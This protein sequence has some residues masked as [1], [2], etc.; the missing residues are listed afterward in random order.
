MN[1]KNKL[2]KYMRTSFPLK[3][4]FCQHKNYANDII[5]DFKGPRSFAVTFRHVGFWVNVTPGPGLRPALVG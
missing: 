2:R 1:G 5:S 3:K 4:V